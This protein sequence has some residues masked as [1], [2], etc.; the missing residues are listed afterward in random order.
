MSDPSDYSQPEFFRFGS[1]S[2]WL[3]RELPSLVTPRSSY[4]VL[5]LG[6]GSGVISCEL[7]QRLPISLLHGVEAQRDWEVHLESNL[8][9]FCRAQRWEV[10]W[11]RVSEYNRE[12][13]QQYDLIV[14]NPP[15]FE[16][17]SGR[18]SA[19]E[20]RNIAHRFVLEPWGEWLRCL[21]RSLAP[22]GEAWFLQKDSALNSLRLPIAPE[23]ELATVKLEAQLRLMRLRRSSAAY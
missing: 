13:A 8:A 17:E 14:C 15:Y 3:A 1:D 9:R 18:P 23:F 20:R 10:S 21:E 4:R 6:I 2:L 11:Q 16:P 5:E 12:G 7:S 19:D 22:A